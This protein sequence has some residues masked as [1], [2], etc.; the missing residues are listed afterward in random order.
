MD[1]EWKT[2]ETI[3][4][5]VSA[6]GSQQQREMK[7]SSARVAAADG[8]G[9][10]RAAAA[11]AT[12]DDNEETKRKVEVAAAAEAAEKALVSVVPVVLPATKLSSSFVETMRLWTKDSP[13][14]TTEEEEC[15]S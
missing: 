2:A 15:G 12:A 6:R 11:V 14:R 9:G 13:R 1:V 7:A 3:A 10:R 4:T 8:D 5:L